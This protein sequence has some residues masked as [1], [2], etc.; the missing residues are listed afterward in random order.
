[1]RHNRPMTDDPPP[2]RELEPEALSMAR[3][4]R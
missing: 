3:A 4:I 2:T 1:M